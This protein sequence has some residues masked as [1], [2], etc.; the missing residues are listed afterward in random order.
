MVILGRTVESH[1]K[2]ATTMNMTNAQHDVIENFRHGDSIVDD[3]RRD[4]DDVVVGVETGAVRIAPNGDMADEPALARCAVC[5]VRAA[6]GVTEATDAGGALPRCAECATATCGAL[7]A[8]SVV[9][10]R[11]VGDVT[12]ISHEHETT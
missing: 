8:T 9:A 4:G 11:L 7:I 5:D 3:P 12:R 1:P 2:G 10:L 6:V